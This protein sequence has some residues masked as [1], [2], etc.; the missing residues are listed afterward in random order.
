[1]TAPI[2]PQP[3]PETLAAT[4]DAAPPRGALGVLFLIVLADLIGFGIIIPLL[5]FYALRFDASPLQVALLFSAYSAVQLVAGPILGAVSDRV[6]R[7]PVLIVSQLGSVVGF[8]LLGLATVSDRIGPTFGLTL[9]YLSRI[10]DGFSGGN[11]TAA[12][13]YVSDVTTPATRSRGMGVIGAAF[14]I[15]FAIGPAV[16]G[17]L[18]HRF[19]HSMP[20]FVAAGFCLLAA[21]L[22]AAML[23]E[24]RAPKPSNSRMWLH[25]SSFAPVVRR[26]VTAQ[27]LGIWFLSMTAFVM[28]QAIFALFLADRYGYGEAAVGWFFA[29]VGLIIAVVQGGLIGRLTKRVGEWPLAAWGPFAVALSMGVYVWAGF[30]PAVWMLVIAG[31]FNAAGRS[32][33][34]PSVQ[35][36]LSQDNPP[37]EQGAAFGLFQALGSLAST[38]GPFIGG[39]LY[40]KASPARMAAPFAL[41]GVMMLVAGA[42]TALLSASASRRRADVST[43]TTTATPVAEV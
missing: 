19:G 31:F 37:H 11:I 36:L 26:P 13:A 40:A 30:A 6:G 14:G 42:W 33:Q 21:I 3:S 43:P 16:G 7:R 2:E 27:L 41:A 18:A 23:K 10:I 1:M 38:I 25:P 34:G 4:D 8:V 28:L 12:Q 15:G 24:S 39:L 32:L 22:T 35:S 9:V 17:L 20:G 5:P 29:Y